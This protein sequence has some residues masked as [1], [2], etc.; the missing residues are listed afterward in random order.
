LKLYPLM[1]N[2]EG[3]SVAVVG[4][5]SV[6]LRKVN[7]LLEYGA[8]V[9]VI[10]PVLKLELLDLSEEGAIRWVAKLFNDKLF[11]EIPNLALVFGT[12]DDRNVNVEIFRAAVERRIPCNIAD[13]PDLCSFTVPAVI[14]RG[15]L[16][17][18]ISTGGASPALA[19]RIRE[20][21]EGHFGQ[22]Y[23]TLTLILGEIRQEVL[24]LGGSSDGNKSMFMQIIDSDLLQA[25]TENN[26]NRVKTILR[27]MLPD[28]ID[29]GPIVDRAMQPHEGG[30]T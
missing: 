22:E 12:T 8:K 13:V 14:S 20:Q 2:I 19:R 30:S 3:K 5:G 21:L 11:D 10:S 9:T 24:G 28:S 7:S 23:V 16:S 1:M 6:A 27:S 26:S 25:I 17:I 15:D 18:A 4:G 29:P